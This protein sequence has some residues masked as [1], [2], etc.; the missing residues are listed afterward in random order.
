[1]AG[2]AFGPRV[3]AM[4]YDAVHTTLAPALLAL[5][6]VALGWPTL[7]PIALIWAAHIG[8]D[9]AVGYGLKYPDSFH[10]THLSWRA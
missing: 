10:A 5:A 6:S 7:I 9:R 1:M 8:F 2:Y 4:A 3:G